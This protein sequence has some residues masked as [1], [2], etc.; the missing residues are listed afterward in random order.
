[1]AL[2][3]LCCA[4]LL[5]LS[6]IMTV[7]LLCSS[8]LSQLLYGLLADHKAACSMIGYWHDTN[9][10]CLSVCLSVCMSV[11]LC[12]VV[13]RVS[14]GFESCTVVFLERHFLFTSLDNFA[15]GCII[16]PQ[17]AAKKLTFRNFRVWS[18]HP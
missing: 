10:V 5:H 7:S 9:V 3:S 2:G 13:L 11:T 6:L 8:S 4:D 15:V 1:M 14:V 17:H 12:I 18:S 16:Q